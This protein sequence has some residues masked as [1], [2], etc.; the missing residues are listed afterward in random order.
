M[1]QAKLNKVDFF[2]TRSIL[3]SLC[4]LYYN[5]NYYNKYLQACIYEQRGR[6]EPSVMTS[7]IQGALQN[8]AARSLPPCDPRLISA[9]LTSGNINNDQTYMPTLLDRAQISSSPIWVT[10]SPA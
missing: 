9:A 7:K 4:L 1:V 5:N 2:L 8:G 3:K 10:K 6:S